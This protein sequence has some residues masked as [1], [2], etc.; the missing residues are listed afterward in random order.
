[1][2]IFSSLLI[3]GF[4]K[5][6]RWDLYEQVIMSE[7]NV[8]DFYATD[9]PGK[10]APKTLYFPGLALAAKLIPTDNFEIKSAI[11]LAVASV[12]AALLLFLLWWGGVALG[13]PRMM[14]LVMILACAVILENWRFYAIEFKPDSIVLVFA[15][16]VVFFLTPRAK[17]EKEQWLHIAASVPLLV[18]AALFKQ[19]AVAVYLGLFLFAVFGSSKSRSERFLEVLGLTIAS[20]I[21]FCILFFIPNCL[22]FA[23]HLIGQHP[24]IALKEQLG[25]LKQVIAGYFLLWIFL[26]VYLAQ[27]FRIGWDRLGA[28]EQKWLLVSMAWFAVSLLSAVKVGG[29]LGNVESGLLP[30]VP[31]AFLAAV[32]L[33]RDVKNSG[34][35]LVSVVSL[36]LVV[37]VIDIGVGAVRLQN[38]S[39]F[40]S[41]FR[42][43]LK[44]LPFGYKALVDGGA[45]LDVRIAGVAPVAEIDTAVGTYG[46]AGKDISD[47]YLSIERGDFD[48]VVSRTPIEAYDDTRLLSAVKSAYRLSSDIRAGGLV[49]LKDHSR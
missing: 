2:L 33:V 44:E 40:N 10:Y 36:V 23:V 17:S 31:F 6:G 38:V 48:V 9:G 16:V 39:K 45:L 21:T 37:L 5:G 26:G 47:F 29:N 34:T 1:M 19:Q 43:Y 14:A 8:S 22:D 32:R 28:L 18:A 13:L 20:S 11:L 4:V 3:D 49:Y 35:I 7:R 12:V 41:Q 27:V 30:L 25:L 42:S 15:M 46:L 24:L